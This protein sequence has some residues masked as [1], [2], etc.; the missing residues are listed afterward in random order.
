[1]YLLMADDC[2]IALYSRAST[3]RPPGGIALIKCPRSLSRM[4]FRRKFARHTRM[5]NADWLE[6]VASP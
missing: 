3:S 5:K 1:M 4:V 6:V 2:R